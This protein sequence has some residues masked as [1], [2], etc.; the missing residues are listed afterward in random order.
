MFRPLFAFPIVLGVSYQTIVAFSQ[1]SAVGG[2]GD[3]KEIQPNFCKS[4]LQSIQ[5]GNIE[6]TKALIVDQEKGSRNGKSMTQCRDGVHRCALSLACSAGYVELAQLLHDAGYS[7]NSL[8]KHNLS[9][10]SYASWKGQIHSVKFL[11]EKGGQMALLRAVNFKTGSIMAP[12]EY[13]AQTL[14]QAPL[15]LVYRG[16]WHL[17]QEKRE[18]MLELLIAYGADPNIQD[19][20]GNTP[21]HYASALGYVHSILRLLQVGADCRIQ[22]KDGERPSDMMGG[23]V[24]W[25]QALPWVLLRGWEVLAGSNEKK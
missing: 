13:N 17:S 16:A 15:H 11:L 22:N 24:I 12:T 14:H 21:L 7:I 25:K 4:L 20:L 18:E 23:L 19:K 3:E 8:D 6:Y 2:S 9:P 1:H 10:L 5:R